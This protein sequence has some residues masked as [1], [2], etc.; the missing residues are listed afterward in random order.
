[1]HACTFLIQPV[2]D[3]LR[4]P[5][6]HTAHQAIPSPTTEKKSSGDPPHSSL[7][8]QDPESPPKSTG[9]LSPEQVHAVMVIFIAKLCIGIYT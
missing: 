3:D 2:Q 1:M 8:S 4:I 9:P 7:G 5:P 6:G